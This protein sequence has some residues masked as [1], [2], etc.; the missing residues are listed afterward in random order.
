VGNL[1]AKGLNDELDRILARSRA[2]LDDDSFD[3][4]FSTPKDLT[5]FGFTLD[6]A[7]GW[8]E[9]LPDFNRQIAASLKPKRPPDKLPVYPIGG[10]ELGIII[11]SVV[12]YDELAEAD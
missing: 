1:T 12:P 2:L 5:L 10:V 3:G 4:R 8:M 6:E 11:N 7:N 9:N